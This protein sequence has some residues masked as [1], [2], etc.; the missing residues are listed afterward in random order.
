[1]K[2]LTLTCGLLVSF[3]LL[4]QK[5]ESDAVFEKIT[6]E[7]TLHDD[8]SMEYHHYKKLRL[9][10]HM[11]F[12]RLYGE[13]FIIYNPGYQALKINVCRTTQE[14]GKVVEAPFNAFNEVLPR[15]AT[16]ATAYNG[17]REMVVTHPGLELGA[18][19]EL[20]YTLTTKAGFHPG[21]MGEEA[22]TESSPV[23]ERELIVHVPAGTE[24]HY[25]V[26]N[27]RTSPEIT[28]GKDGK[29][30][31]FAFKGLA[32][33]SHED[34]QPADGTHLPRVLFSTLTYKEAIAAITDQESFG[35][36]VDESLQA[37]A[38]QL[39]KDN[40]DDTRLTLA[41]QKMVAEE[42]NTWSVPHYYTG[43][44]VRTAPE[45][46]N[47]NGGT[48]CEKALMMTA[49]LRAAGINASPVI[50][51]PTKVYGEENGCLPAVADILL[52]V[53]PRDKEQMYVSPVSTANQNLVF[54]MTDKTI[55]L[56]EPT[57]NYVESVSETFAN[58]VITNGDLVLDKD[59]RAAGKMEVSLTERTNP[60]YAFLNDSTY[61]KKL[62]GGGISGRDI[63]GTEIMNT[64]QF[65]SLASLTVE[66][67]NGVTPM[68][69]YGFWEIPVN[70]AGSDSWRIGHLGAD[71]SSPFEVP[72][73]L[74]EEY[75]Y[76][77]VVPDGAELVNPV[78]LTERDTPFGSLVL[79]TQQ[80]G[81]TV[82]VKR[83]LAIRERIIAPEH[84]AAF[85]E[86]MDLWNEKNFR[87]L[88]FRMDQED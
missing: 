88:V 10:T 50:L 34:H 79:S 24:L 37:V 55:L 70:K 71:R 47:A 41:L 54:S 1:M 26:L 78:E 46:W 12:N 51:V 14:D 64:A 36:K 9:N 4:A 13:T 28:D 69:E 81:N 84:Y 42:M 68:G 48:A 6:S 7:Y 45:T 16:G 62:V 27:M 80:K 31:T 58:K 66:S 40:S 33:S 25:Q 76:S 29:T 30:Y 57:K 60:Y 82:T 21:L 49:I 86:I 3:A 72:F 23:R 83:L 8:G 43:Y 20:D 52:Q 11:S 87:Q 32:E 39:R 44:Q 77:I 65:R 56:L 63:T 59:L 74:D 17:L 18:V 53:N 38:D 85:K 15:F 19:I 73:T 35:F 5:A 67:K 22:L 75:S 61:A 2:I